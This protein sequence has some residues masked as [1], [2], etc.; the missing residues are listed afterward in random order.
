MGLHRSK[1]EAGDGA[2]LLPTTN[3]SEQQV[4]GI[5]RTHAAFY[6]AYV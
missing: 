6:I 3:T 4:T 1:N 2:T 5:A